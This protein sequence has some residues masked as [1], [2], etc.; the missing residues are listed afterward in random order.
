MTKIAILGYGTV[1]GGVARVLDVNPAQVAA[2][3]G[4]E[5]ALGAILDLREFPGDPHEALVT[6]DY[7]TILDDPS[8]TVIAET[9]GGV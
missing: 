7:Q 1:G 6:H 4:E 3:A 2:S 9:M 5:V 8:I